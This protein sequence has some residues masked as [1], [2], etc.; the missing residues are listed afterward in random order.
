MKFLDIYILF[1]QNVMWV[2]HFF[3]TYKGI[4]ELINLLAKGHLREGILNID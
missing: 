4:N 1:L 3:I 2:S